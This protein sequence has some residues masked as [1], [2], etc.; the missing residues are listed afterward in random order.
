MSAWRALLIALVLGT[1]G[2]VGAGMAGLTIAPFDATLTCGSAPC[3]ATGAIVIL[4]NL[5]RVDIEV[6]GPGAGIVYA[7]AGSPSNVVER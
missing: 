3:E 6:R 5:D 4:P 1:S 2:G 7:P